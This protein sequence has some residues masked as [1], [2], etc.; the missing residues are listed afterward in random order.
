[1]YTSAEI[2]SMYW[3]LIVSSD[4]FPGSL[5]PI[6][7]TLWRRGSSTGTLPSWTTMAARTSTIRNSSRS[8]GTWRRKPSPRSVPAGSPTIATWTRIEPSP[9]RSWRAAWASARRVRGERRQ[10]RGG[11]P[12]TRD[13]TEVFFNQNWSF[14]FYDLWLDPC[15]IV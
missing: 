6:P 8:R 13:W 1:M 11:K 14:K 12:A 5:S 4:L 2:V 9:C 15:S 7:A 10:G 3:V